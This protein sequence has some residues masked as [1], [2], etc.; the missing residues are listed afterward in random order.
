MPDKVI[1]VRDFSGG[2][3]TLADP[4]VLPAHQSSDL[5]NVEILDSRS[6]RRR[7]GIVPIGSALKAAPMKALYRYYTNFLYR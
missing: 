2:L 5:M 1:T 6:I 7:K 3:N 4:A